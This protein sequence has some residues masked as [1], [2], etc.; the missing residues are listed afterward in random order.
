MYFTKKWKDLDIT[1]DFIFA[2]VMQDEKL[3]KKLL[4][5]LLKIKIKKVVLKQE[6]KAIDITRNGRSVR[7]DIYLEDE[8]RI[9][10]LEMQVSN[11]QNLAKR[12]R[13]YQSMVD[14]NAL[15][16]GERFQTLKESYIIFI[17]TFDPFDKGLSRYSFQNSCDENPTLL[18]ED[19]SYKIFFNAKGFANEA[20]EDSKAFLQ[21]VNGELVDNDLVKEI[22]EYK[23]KANNCE[24]WEVEYMKWRVMEQDIMY[25]SK[26]AGLAEG[27]A[28]GLEQGKTETRETREEDI[29]ILVQILTSLKMTNDTIIEML[30]EKYSLSKSSAQKYLSNSL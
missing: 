16:K 14:L 13:Y 8:E 6:Q 17:C 30:I 7:F 3:C 19:G 23:I 4:E 15:Q 25:E 28:E 5:A 29:K 9:F 24:E 21:Y 2:K 27:L 12:S 20:D 1:S 11:D 22:D 18:L 26:A 10:D